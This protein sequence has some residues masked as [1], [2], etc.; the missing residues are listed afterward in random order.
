MNDPG[1]P[2]RLAA[3]RP[4]PASVLP[5]RTTVKHAPRFLVWSNVP[6]PAATAI[7]TDAASSDCIPAPAL[8]GSG[9]PGTRDHGLWLFHAPL[10]RREDW[11]RLHAEPVE[12]TPSHPAR[13]SAYSFAKRA[14]DVVLS[15]TF[16]TLLAPV[17][18]LIALL[19]RLDSPGPAFFRQRRIGLDGREFLM[20]KFRSMYSDSPAYARSPTTAHDPRLTRVGRL[21]RRISLDEFPQL[22]NVL[23]G[24][25]SLV[26]PRPEMPFIVANYNAL[27]R[28]RLAVKPGITG[29]WQISP[30]RAFPIHENLQ[31]DL[32]YITHRNLIFDAAI[33]LRTLTAVVRGVGAV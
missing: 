25:M 11:L 12:L 14:A 19:I 15:L 2:R 18:L 4:E 26:G 8:P 22:L 32:H 1:P 30:A 3:A 16:L 9:F 28:R 13:R 7:H 20:W 21:I 24:D 33:L 23:S 17:F 10:L 5:R 6:R 31:F 29:L 27:Q